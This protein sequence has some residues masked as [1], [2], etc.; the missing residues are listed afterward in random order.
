MCFTLDA[1][2]PALAAEGITCAG[3]VPLSACRLTRSYLLER[4]GLPTA[5]GSVLMMALP[6]RAEDEESANLSAYAIPPDYHGVA[7]ALFARLIP[8]L[9]SAFP[10]ARLAGFS[11]HAPIDERHAA[12][13]AGLGV[14][15]DNGLLITQR[16]GSYVFLAEVITD[17]PTDALPGE[18]KGC[19]HCGACRAACPVGLDHSRCL[20]ALTQK[21]GE[22]TPEEAEQIIAHGSAWG[23]D[24]CQ[25]VCPYNRGAL[26]APLPAF[27]ADRIP[28]LSTARI[29][30]MDD[31]AFARRAYAWRGRAVILRNLR[32]LEEAAKPN[33]KGR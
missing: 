15:G 9:A 12:A 21:K 7:S 24:I 14:I 5:S 10:G 2:R 4:A 22:L 19:A 16:Y 27:T 33:M 3:I 17:L 1:V 13:I 30:A 20:S 29:E 25:N 11:D 18:V 8:S 28:R 26:C 31:A 32:L 6:Y 23:C